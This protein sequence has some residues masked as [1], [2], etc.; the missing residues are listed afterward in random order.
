MC[1]RLFCIITYWFIATITTDKLFDSY[2]LVADFT[3]KS[4]I[5][6]AHELLKSRVYV[7][8]RDHF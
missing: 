2:I 6:F 5:S 7:Q 8:T 1:G 4:P 3:V